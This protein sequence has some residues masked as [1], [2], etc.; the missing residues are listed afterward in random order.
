[1]I[2][3][4]CTATIRPKILEATLKSFKELLFK[5]HPC[6]LIINIDPV[7]EAIDRKV[8][9][10]LAHS[11]FN[12]MRFGLPLKAHFGR[13]FVWTWDMA[14]TFKDVEYLFHL[15]DDWQLQKEVDLQEMLSL[16]EK[17]ED[18]VGLR[19]SSKKTEDRA[20]QWNKFFPWNGEFFECPENMRGGLG[21]SG[22]PT[23]YKA[24]FIKKIYQHL[25]PERNPEKQ[26]HYTKAIATEVKKHR[27]GVFAKQNESAYIREIGER[28]KIE[29][30]IRK[31]GGNKAYF[32]NWKHV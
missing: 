18:L 27:F 25:N 12:N 17:H 19:L 14:M 16:M 9:I 26:L 22:H 15:E 2:I 10:E 7:G 13:A 30:N 23:L 28:W 21:M 5:D 32:V 29:N 11:Y 20:K 4:T 6:R 8:L 31:D 24:S 1:M 3:I